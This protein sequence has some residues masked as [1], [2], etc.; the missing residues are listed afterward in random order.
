MPDLTPKQDRFCQEYLVDLNATQAAERAS[1]KDPNYGRQ[2]LTKTNVLK[3]IQELKEARAEKTGITA[4]RVVQELAAIGLC[5]LTDLCEWD[6]GK[7]TLLTSGELSERGKAGVHKIKIGKDDEIEISLGG[8]VQALKLL[9]QHTGVIGADV[10][11]NINNSIEE[12]LDI[13][14]ERRRARGDEV[15]GD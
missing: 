11:V 14:A 10:Q 4:E 2:L 7:V 9:A 13:I 1:Y 5:R 8:K 12:A 3:K 6:A 15:P